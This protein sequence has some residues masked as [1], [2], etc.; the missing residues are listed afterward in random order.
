MSETKDTLGKKE[1]LADIELKDLDVIDRF[2]GHFELETPKYLTQAIEEYKSVQD[3]K[4]EKNLKLNLLKA[5]IDNRDKVEGLDE[6]FTPVIN[7]AGEMAYNLQ[8]DKDLEDVLTQEDL[9]SEESPVAEQAP[10]A[11]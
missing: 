1:E 8:F 7:A 3:L 2:F 10:S 6:L 9:S 11:E 4:T 5:V